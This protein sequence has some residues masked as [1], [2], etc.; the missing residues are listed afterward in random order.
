MEPSPA[1]P[2]TPR[3]GARARALLVILGCVALDQG[4]KAVARALLDPNRPYSFLGDAL[5]LVL[6]K[7]PGAFLGLGASL[8]P[9]VRDALFTW[10]VLALVLGAAWVAVVRMG[11][12]RVTLGAALVAGGGLGNLWDRIAS[13]GY[14]TDFL[15]L[16]LGDVR[17]GVFNVADLAIVGGAVLLLLPARRRHAPAP[18]DAS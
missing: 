7:N 3:A 12:R 9:L 10:G 4:S 14:V 6:V 17:T 5:R 13:S 11:S 8:P 2:T 18:H 15:N 1:V 16:G